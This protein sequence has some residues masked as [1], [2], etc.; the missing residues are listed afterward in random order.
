MAYDYQTE[1]P[2]VFTDEGQR[3]LLSIRDLIRGHIKVAGCCTIEKAIMGQV[4]SSW[5]MLACV[6][7]LKELGEI[8]IIPNPN[9]VT[10]HGIIWPCK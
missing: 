2:W 6:D 4:G 8:K 10:Q 3:Q 1:R 5:G 9:G 7:R